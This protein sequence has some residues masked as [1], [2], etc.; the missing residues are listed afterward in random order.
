MACAYWMASALHLVGR[1]DEAR[2]LLEELMTVPNHNG[3]LA[4]MVDP[5]TGEFWGNLP[6]A[7]SHLALMHAVITVTSEDSP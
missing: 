7:L 4:E 6:Q 3:V 5:K 2:T 1:S